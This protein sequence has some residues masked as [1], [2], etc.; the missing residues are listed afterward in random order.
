MVVAGGLEGAAEARV[1]FG[2]AA[3]CDVCLTALHGNEGFRNH[4]WAQLVHAK[5]DPLALPGFFAMHQRGHDAGEPGPCSEKVRI[6]L[7]DFGGGFPYVAGIGAQAHGRFQRG[8]LGLVRGP[9]TA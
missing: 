9:R 4:Q 2:V 5:I 7:S 3:A 8:A 6:R 1:P